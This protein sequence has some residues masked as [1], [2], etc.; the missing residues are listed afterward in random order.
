[1]KILII[2]L[3]KKNNFND[4]NLKIEDKFLLRILCSKK[5]NFFFFLVKK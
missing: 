2:I 4:F 3:K 1:M 5:N